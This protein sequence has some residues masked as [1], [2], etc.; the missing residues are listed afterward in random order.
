MNNQTTLQ[1]FADHLKQADGLLITAGA[2]MGVDSGLPDFRGDNGFWKAYPP[3]Q[4]LG[5]NFKEMATPQL[6]NTN[7]RLAWGFYGLRL[8]QYRAIVPHNGFH[9]LKHW[10]DSLPNLTH[11][12]FVFTSNVDGEFQKVG[13]DETKVF[14]CHGSIHWLQC[15]DNCTP[16]IWSADGYTPVVDAEHCQLTGDLPKCRH[17]GSLARPNILMFQDWLWQAD[18]QDVK[19]KAL[20]DWLKQVKNL[21]IIELGAGDDVATVRTFSEKLVR[22]NRGKTVSL[23]RINPSMP[24]VPA[25]LTN[26]YGVNLGALDALTQLNE[27]LTA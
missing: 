3:L 24:D 1:Q 20:S 8:L 17:C 23:L 11:G 5:I 6:F 14:E 19:E 18:Y 2:G 22:F 16:D 21:A 4:K 15:V 7:P 26:V 12:S 27:I 13:F 10:S 25:D 9:L